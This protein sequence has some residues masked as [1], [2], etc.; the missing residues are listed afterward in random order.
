MRRALGIRTRL[1]EQEQ[2]IEDKFLRVW[3]DWQESGVRD[4][5]SLD[6]MSRFLGLVHQRSIF[7][8]DEFY[9]NGKRPFECMCSWCASD[10]LFYVARR[11]SGLASFCDDNLRSIVNV[12]RR[13]RAIFPVVVD[14]RSFCY[15]VCTWNTENRHH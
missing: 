12:W 7:H 1:E 5:L 11:D 6:P 10:I 14:F 13:L 15:V 8:S 4:E 9:H 2:K 3:N